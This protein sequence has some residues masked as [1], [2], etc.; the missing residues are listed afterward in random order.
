MLTK[1][2]L[3]NN[4]L[5]RSK[6]EHIISLYNYGKYKEA[7][8]KAYKLHKKYPEII[9]LNNIL[10]L[11][12]TNEKNFD[13][14]IAYFQKAIKLKPDYAVIYNNLANVYKAQG[15]LNEAKKYYKKALALDPNS[16]LTYNNLGSLY[17]A[18]DEFDNSVFAAGIPF[19][20]LSSTFNI[21]CDFCFEYL[22]PTLVFLSTC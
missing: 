11:I 15:N 8:I 20:R 6:T 2:N 3:Q 12:L 9:I 21:T 1:K 22:S 17:A 5:L 13:E 14:A 18:L 4:S 16:A 10:G 19:L 7:K